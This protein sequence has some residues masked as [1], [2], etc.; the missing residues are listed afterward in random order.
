MLNF[1]NMDSLSKS[2]CLF[3]F[4]RYTEVA[5]DRM[6][7]KDDWQEIVKYGLPRNE[8]LW[9]YFCRWS[10]IFRS[11]NVAFCIYP[12]TRSWGSLYKKE[13][14]PSHLVKTPSR[15]SL[16]AIFPVFDMEKGILYVRLRSYILLFK[17][18]VYI[19]L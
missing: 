12:Q 4:M 1:W 19:R 9:L 15:V 3:T 2:H 16:L 17:S 18:P 14:H 6:H 7:F 13:Q 11:H 8:F 5:S 10:K